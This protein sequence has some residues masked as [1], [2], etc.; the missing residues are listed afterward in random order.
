MNV[1]IPFVPFRRHQPLT[2]YQS[3]RIPHWRQEGCTYFV[4]FRLADSLPKE[5]LAKIENERRSWLDENGGDFDSLSEARKFE[6][7]RHY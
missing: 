1:P 3:N 5:A 4:T 7:L 2:V 6:Y